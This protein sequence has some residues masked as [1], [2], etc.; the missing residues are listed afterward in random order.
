MKITGE[1]RYR[2]HKGKLILQVEYG[3][4]YNDMSDPTYGKNPRDGEV[5]NKWRDANIYD[6]QELIKKGI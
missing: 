2:D 1:T 3:S 6:L 4:R 5:T